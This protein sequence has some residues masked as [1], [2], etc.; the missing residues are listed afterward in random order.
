MLILAASAA[1]VGFVHSLA[2]GHWLPVVILAKARRWPVRRVML[3]AV[4]AASG[5]ILISN[6]IGL[7]SLAL[8]KSVELP[9][10][11]MERWGAL[12]L[13]A[14]GVIY[15]GYSYF[16]HSSCHGHGH[17]GPDPRKSGKTPFLFLFSLGFSPCAAVIPIFAAAGLQ[18]AHATFVTMITFSAGVLAS[19]GL[20]TFLGTHG[21]KKF[22]H[23]LL[24]HYGDV[25][26]GA[27]LVLMGT[28]L[29]FFPI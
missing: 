27:S 26:T 10:E 23:P 15:A 24:E 28:I 29:Y 17:H 13:V 3:G 11:E 5:H 18:G 20:T 12:V 9:H 21:M 22:D 16:R 6:S 7:L 4:V 19:L 14:F 2:P 8:G 25:I 1:F